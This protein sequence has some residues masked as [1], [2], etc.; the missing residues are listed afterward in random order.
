ML[1]LYID[2]ITLV[3]HGEL[4]R[5]GDRK[6]YPHGRHAD[7]WDGPMR[8][9]D[10]TRGKVDLPHDDM[11]PGGFPRVSL[12]WPQLCTTR[13]MTTE[14]ASGECPFVASSGLSVT[15]QPPSVA[16]A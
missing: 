16:S 12:E 7:L 15:K 9:R 4:G 6:V 2:F 1:A 8:N 11:H 5:I 3:K 13:R 14:H 10:A